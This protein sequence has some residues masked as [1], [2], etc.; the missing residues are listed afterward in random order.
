[1][2]DVTRLLAAILTASAGPRPTPLQRIPD[3]GEWTG[4]LIL[5]GRGFGKSFSAMWWLNRQAIAKPGLRARVLAPTFGDAVASCVDGP[6]GLV[7]RA[8]GQARFN[9]SAPGGA[10]VSY[11]NGSRVW[12]VG[13]NTIRDIDRLR[14]LTNMHVD[15]YEEA[16]AIPYLREAVEQAT[17][18]R[19]NTSHG[20]TRWVATTTPRPIPQIKTWLADKGVTVV[21]ATTRDNPHLSEEFVAEM[22]RLYAGTRLY[23]Q[24]VLGEVLDTVEGALWTSADL[25]RSRLLDHHDTIRETASRIV[26]GVDPPSG[27]GTCGI[28]VAAITPDNHLHI[29]DDYSVTDVTPGEWARAVATASRDWGDCAVVAETNQGGKMVTEVLKAAN[30]DLTVHT[31]TAAVGKAARAEPVALLWEANEPTAHITPPPGKPH[32]PQL[33]A[34]LTEWVPGTYS[35]DRLDAMVWACTH[36]RNRNH[37]PARV[38]MARGQIGGW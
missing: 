2:S 6:N 18:S 37:K 22:E 21:R 32:L 25:D 9:P 23:R 17:L 29:L 3:D 36:L 35:P 34:Q 15:V 30:P 11:R 19:R 33:E 27:T 5:A 1:V 24:E 16:A 13:C 38:T 20:P 14:A 10:C 4:H 7:A 31:V 28:V 12:V 26:V 8:A